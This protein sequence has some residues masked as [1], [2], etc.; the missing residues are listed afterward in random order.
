MPESQ[1]NQR[2]IPARAGN[3]ERPDPPLHHQWD[4]P[5]SRGDPFDGI[6]SA[7]GHEGSS[8]LARGTH[9]W[10]NPAYPSLGIIPARAGNTYWLSLGRN[11]RLGS[12]PLARGTRWRFGDRP[13]WHGDHPR[14]RGEHFIGTL[15][16]GTAT[17]SSPLARG[18][19]GWLMLLAVAAG[20]IP[21]RAGNTAI[22]TQTSNPRADH[23][24]SR[25]EH[26]RP[27]SP[28]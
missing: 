25:G 6:A 1:A 5:R 4:H 9:T 13:H 8:P 17:G 7:S 26:F 14:S 28:A 19:P 12:S 16:S 10:V 23:P 3:T 21:A 22:A 11:C 2:I 15:A 18:T 24:R 27:T 20:I